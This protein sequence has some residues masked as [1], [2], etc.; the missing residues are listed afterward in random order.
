MKNLIYMKLLS[1]NDN[2][3]TLVVSAFL[4]DEKSILIR[5]KNVV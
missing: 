1:L 4:L 5:N 3:L 2:N